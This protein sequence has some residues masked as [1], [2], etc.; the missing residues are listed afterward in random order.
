LKFLNPSSIILDWNNNNLFFGSIQ[1]SSEM[2]VTITASQGPVRSF[3]AKLDALL[4]LDGFGCGLLPLEKKRIRRLK[5]ELEQ[6]I[7][8]YLVEPAD[9]SYAGCT[10]IC[11]VK[12]VAE[13]A[14]DIDDGV[15][16][17]KHECADSKKRLSSLRPSLDNL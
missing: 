2:D 4:L 3:P 16:K 17:L 6:L 14:Y 12:E 9:V 5:R 13:L 10:V 8:E 15:D 1:A 7:S 11:W